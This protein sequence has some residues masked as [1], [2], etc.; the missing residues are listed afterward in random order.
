[1]KEQIEIQIDNDSFLGYLFDIAIDEGIIQF[2]ND[3]TSSSYLNSLG[4]YYST[5]C[6]LIDAYIYNNTYMRLSVDRISSEASNYNNQ[7][8]LNRIKNEIINLLESGIPVIVGGSGN[9]G[10]TNNDGIDER[11]GHLGIAYYYDE[12]TDTIY[13]NLGY[14]SAAVCVDMEEFFNEGINT[15]YALDIGYGFKQDYTNNYY[16]TDR[17]ATYSPYNNAIY[18][19][20]NPSDYGFT[21]NQNNGLDERIVNIP[22]SNNFNS[23]KFRSLN[24]G[25]YGNECLLVTPIRVNLSNGY[26][27]YEFNE[28]IKGAILQMSVWTT[29]EDSIIYNSTHTIDYYSSNSWITLRDITYELTYSTNYSVIDLE[30]DFPANTNRFRIN[31]L[32][33]TSNTD[34]GEVAI[35]KI[36]IFYE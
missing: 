24:C 9:N 19:I 28:T 25:Y 15:Y 29:L 13:G 3:G 34:D 26:A 1:M 4:V 10:D 27:D 35:Y 6:D 11:Y 17:H 8:E 21:N 23:F 7:S 20:I 32:Y 36:M 33:N 18:N 12:S 30:A 31:S 2:Y 16:F 22:S 14:G 5:M